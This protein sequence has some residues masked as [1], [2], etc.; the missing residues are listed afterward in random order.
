MRKTLLLLAAFT[1]AITSCKK[2]SSN[3]G[4]FTCTCNYAFQ[5]GFYWVN[6]TAVSVTYASGTSSTDAQLYCTNQQS[7]YTADS[8]RKH[9]ACYIH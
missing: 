6:D 5:R 9:V 1:I 3:N 4:P 2:P 7:T 8:T